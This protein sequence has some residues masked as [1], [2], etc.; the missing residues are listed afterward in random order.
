MFRG[1][2]ARVRGLLRRSRAHA[3]ADEEIQFHLEMEM[4]ANI[5][6]G[7]TPAEARRVALR[8]LGGV[9]QAREAVR[10]VRT[11]WFDSTW[12]DLRYACRSL[13][14]RPGVFVA[15]VAMLALGIGITTAM[16]TVVDALILRP[17]P[18]PKPDE[19]AFIYMGNEH[20]GRA[21]LLWR[22]FAR[23]NAVR[24]SHV[25]SRLGRIRP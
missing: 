10:E 3:E 18:F 8:D 12:Q 21:M 1:F 25:R 13:Q 4:Q 17:V 14:R 16:F 11:L 5:A 19:L 7:M 22:S 24:P 9:T 2:A 23:G 20:G 6:R 15:A